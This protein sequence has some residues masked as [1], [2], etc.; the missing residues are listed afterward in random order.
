MQDSVLD[1]RGPGRPRTFHDEYWFRRPARDDSEATIMPM[2]EKAP[3]DRACSERE[4]SNG[5]ESLTRKVGIE[6]RLFAMGVTP[7]DQ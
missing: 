5:V 3:F 6:I 4:S 2:L 1:A 7:A